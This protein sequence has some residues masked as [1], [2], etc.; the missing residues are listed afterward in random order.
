MT[1][2]ARRGSSRTGNAAVRI[3]RLVNAQRTML[4]GASHELRSPLARM[5]MA[6][7]LLPHAERPE[8]QGRLTQDIAE[9]DALGLRSLNLINGEGRKATKLGARRLLGS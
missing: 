8:L 7:E 5:R 1:Q 9:L 2:Q 3:A 4:A 6:I